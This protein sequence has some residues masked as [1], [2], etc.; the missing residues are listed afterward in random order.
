M[1]AVTKCVSALSTLA[2]GASLTVGIT[3][4]TPQEKDASPASR[5]TL[6]LLPDT[7]F[8]SR[9]ATEETG[10][11]YQQRYG[12][13]P[14]DTQTHF[15]VDHARDLNI[16]FTASLGDVVDQADHPQQWQVA[17]RAMKVLEDGGMNYS[18]LPGNHDINKDE[19]RTTF[20]AER[21]AKQPTFQERFGGEGQE[22]EY[23][24][25]EAEGQKY[26]ML[27]VA[28]LANDETL[29]WAQ[30]VLDKH[31]NIPTI[32]TSHEI[33]MNEKPE[34]G[35]T[36][37]QF[38]P[39]YGQHFW[40]KLIAPNDQVFLTVAGH[41]HGAG[42]RIDK[43]QKGHEVINVL[44]DYQMAYQGG[45][46]LLGLLQFDLTH[47]RMDMTALSPW[48]ARKPHR[49]LNQF[50]DLILDNETDSWSAPFDFRSR[51][52]A[53]NPEWTVGE[54]DD[55]DYTQVARSIVQQDFVPPADPEK[56]RARDAED[57]PHQPGTAAHWR[58]GAHRGDT[59]PDIA[60]G[61]DMHRAPL[62]NGVSSGSKKEDVRFTSDH[63]PQSSDFGS[64]C[65]QAPGDNDKRISWFQTEKDAPINGETFPDGYTME[66]FVRVDKTFTRQADEW[67]GAISR[68]GRR[69]DV[70]SDIPEGDEPPATLALSS[71]RELQW[72]SVASTGDTSGSS[73]WSHEVPT[74]E[75]LHV[76]VVNDPKKNT[77]E[78]FVNGAPI[79]R[80][81]LGSTGL[82]TTGDRWIMGTSVWDG[83]PA[84]GW[85]GC[86]GETRL[87]HGA[88]D[89]DQWL[90][91][92][93]HD[94]QVAPSLDGSSGPGSASIRG[95]GLSG[96]GFGSTAFGSR[97]RGSL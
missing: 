31:K 47:G 27:A 89:P 90:S 34:D 16:P 28:D 29:E 39:D 50:D 94:D 1:R 97:T 45:N 55:A 95:E 79:L 46:G 86:I 88:L 93:R 6:G 70:A 32:V 64:V 61:Q 58:P 43:N 87:T 62:D 26:L 10:N 76:A 22:S 24:I 63:H 9:Y 7:Q 13:E 77:V 20:S 42:Y 38:T 23:H 25:F 51:F 59:I 71:L 12:S 57:Y 49:T 75:W 72:S 44:Q 52:T 37:V 68:L 33:L 54:E 73:N 19:F 14:Y 8:Y 80:D 92:R 85:N 67:M 53:I 84:N 36:P 35:H 5:F 69:G 3:S 56:F 83:L 40:D 91:A 66:T 60:Q 48:V 96:G 11:L 30:S 78:M 82:A 2:I 17:D 41:N 74:D 15:L 65:F 21:A 4:A 81:Q 18:I